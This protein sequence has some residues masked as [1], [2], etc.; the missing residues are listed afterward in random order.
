MSSMRG[1]IS[2]REG[3]TRKKYLPRLRLAV[4]LFLG[5]VAIILIMIGLSE[6]NGARQSIFLNLGTE[7]GGSILLIFIVEYLFSLNSDS[8]VMDKLEEIQRSIDILKGETKAD[9]MFFSQ[10]ESIIHKIEEALLNDRNHSTQVF[11]YKGYPS[12]VAKEAKY[13][14]AVILAI[15]EGYIDTYHRIMT[16]KEESDIDKSIESMKMLC[17]ERSLTSSYRFYMNY[18]QY[19][20]YMTFVI[21]EECDC[22]VVFPNLLDPVEIVGHK[23]GVYV[24]DA[25]VVRN[26]REVFNEIKSQKFT[27][28]V[29][30]PKDLHTEHSWDEFWQ[31]KR[32]EFGEDLTRFRK[33]ESHDSK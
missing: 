6:G 28:R 16:I 7:V 33:W 23:C 22:F 12:P 32:I 17:G 1:S 27:R 25:R 2:K 31:K 4:Y 24:N 3:R 14:E 19:G 9:S 8:D 13:Y 30:I 29:E 20:N 15:K 10:Y 11:V 18:L 26:L 5:C 21:L